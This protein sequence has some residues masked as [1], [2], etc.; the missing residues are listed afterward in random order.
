MINSGPLVPFGIAVI[1]FCAALIVVP[2]LRGKSELLTAWNMLLVGV[3]IYAGFGSLEVRYVNGFAWEFLNWYQPTKHEIQWYMM[4]I[5]AFIAA[6]VIAYY[7]NGPA[8]RFAE[9]RL[10][11]WPNMNPTATFF[12]LGCCAVIVAISFASRRSLFLGPI[13]FNLGQ[14]GAVFACVFSYALWCR[15]RVNVATLGMFVG[16]FL[17]A[18]LYAMLASGGRRLLISMFLAPIVCEYWFNV[19]HWKP[20]KTLTAVGIAAVAVLA[21]TT[22]YST[23]RWY[24]LAGQEERT[25]G[26]LIQQLAKAKSNGLISTLVS[27]RLSYFTQ[28]NGHYGLLAQRYVDL[29]IMPPVPLNTLRFVASYPI[30]R[31]LWPDKPEVV[32]IRICRVSN[33]FGTNW[34]VGIVGHG[35][36]E[37][38]IL[39][40]M[41]YGV[42]FAF[43]MRI[44]DDPLKLQPTNPF[45]I[46]IQASALPN[47]L[48]IPR[49]DMGVLIITIAFPILFAVIAGIAC[50]TLFGTQRN[51]VPRVQRSAY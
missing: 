37:G 8:K 1:V 35:A 3:M 14:N 26:G 43:L 51:F 21:V 23:F 16:V 17:C 42:M 36:Y 31:K 15:N 39:A 5:T 34:G 32:A 11:T 33:I 22:V 12:V 47:I 19:R 50:R 48:A 27:T 10:R 44:F 25:V 2:F 24:N 9:R 38:G 6:L 20:V 13:F 41:L 45:L 30:P 49:G 46:A 18:A 7:Y 40:L 4:A 28:Q 29:G